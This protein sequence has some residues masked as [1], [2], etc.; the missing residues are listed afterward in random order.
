MMPPIMASISRKSSYEVPIIIF[1]CYI[2]GDEPIIIEQFFYGFEGV[3]MGSIMGSQN[4]MGSDYGRNISDGCHSISLDSLFQKTPIINPKNPFSQEMHLK[5]QLS[6]RGLKLSNS[7]PRCRV[8]ALHLFVKWIPP[9]AF[10]FPHLLIP[11]LTP[12]S[13]HHYT[14]HGTTAPEAR[15]QHRATEFH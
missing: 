11:R 5:I 9:L 1:R 6:N 3:I 13:P 10:C 2:M 12:V 4:I 15:Q 8:S 14:V 7:K